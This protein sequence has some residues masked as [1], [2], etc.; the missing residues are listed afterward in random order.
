VTDSTTNRHLGLRV[1]HVSAV[2]AA[3]WAMLIAFP[4]WVRADGDPAS[5]VLA[6]QALFLPQDAGIPVSQ[7]S[8][9]SELLH[10]AAQDGY[11]IRAALIATRSDLGSVSELWGQPQPYAAFLSQELGLVYQGPLLVV[12]PDGFGVSGAG[13]SDRSVL[14]GVRVP[15]GPG[16]M[17]SAALGAIQRLAAA[18]GHPLSVP[19]PSA[20][21][22]G[23][24]S[25]H[26]AS[27]IVFGVGAALIALAWTAS[28][29]A[30]PPRL[31]RVRNP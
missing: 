25:S 27:V 18:A 9:L 22:T 10:A 28:L 8:Q 12:M 20:T 4:A 29:R 11:A 23:A 6:T 24:R 7:Q 15:A 3:A 17:G 5:D 2:L 16:A 19:P 31:R 1:R 14:A 13:A 30:R 26:A 21:A